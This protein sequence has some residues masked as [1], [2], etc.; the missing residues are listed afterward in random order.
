MIEFK[1]IQI[2]FGDF[3][4]VDQ[5]NL[6]IQKNEFF[7][8]LGSSGSGKST[9]LNALSGFIQPTK[10]SIF[11]EDKNITNQPVEKR[12]IGMVFQS[13]ALFPSL[14]VYENI[15]FG[16]RIQ[17]KNK[18][19]IEER[20]QELASLVELT[21]EQLNKEVSQL[22]GGQQQ[23]VAIARG[24]AT[25]PKILLLDEPLSNLDAKLRK[26]LRRE[27]KTIQQK[28]GI[29]MI[30]VTHDQDEALSLSDRIAVFNQG[31]IEQVGTPSEIYNNPKTEFV[32]NFLGN[33]NKLNAA[34]IE[35][36]NKQTQSQLDITKVS[37]LREERLT[38]LPRHD[39]KHAAIDA[40]LY[41]Y[42]FFGSTIR[43]TFKYKD[44]I[45]HTFE[46]SDS[47]QQG[48]DFSI[49]SQHTLYINP[50]NINQFDK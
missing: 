26:Q 46:K 31:R 44:T 17:K 19:A 25:G 20:V 48:I 28:Y 40:E 37:Y 21:N 41:D 7:T 22:S 35:E 1:N 9:T 38:N 27:L 5:L 23:R 4:A 8:L 24:L 16:L 43:Y 45:L 13:Y 50:K 29:T 30:Y 33:S 42:E 39:D 18:E 2:K 47:M 34:F 14:N 15:A 3:V 49:G 12:E 11:L 32:N 10:G 36:I 6:T